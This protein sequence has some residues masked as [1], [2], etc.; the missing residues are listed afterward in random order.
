M[1]NNIDNSVSNIVVE[2]ITKLELPKIEEEIIINALKTSD[3]ELKVNRNKNGSI[4]ILTITYKINADA[5]NDGEKK[6]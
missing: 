4:S 5:Y 2:K 6:C 1:P 3:F